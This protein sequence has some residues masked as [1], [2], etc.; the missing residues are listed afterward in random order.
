MQIGPIRRTATMRVGRK[1]YVEE[2]IVS[3]PHGLIVPLL[4]CASGAIDPGSRAAE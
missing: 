2:R 3:G 1:R 4:M